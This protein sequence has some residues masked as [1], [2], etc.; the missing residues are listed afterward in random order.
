M[1]VVFGDGRQE[2]ANRGSERVMNDFVVGGPCL[3]RH[4]LHR[5]SK[6]CNKCDREYTGC[7]KIV[8]ENPNEVL[9]EGIIL[10]EK[11]EYQCKICNNIIAI[12]R[13]FNR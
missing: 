4:G 7:Q 5:K 8:Y 12:Y 3:A 1:Y 9:G 11:G 10:I 2:F 13:K 6:T